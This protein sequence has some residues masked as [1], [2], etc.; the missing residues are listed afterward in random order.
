MKRTALILLL[1]T[2]PASADGG[3]AGFVVKVESSTVYLDAGEGSLA[4]P[5]RA[6]SVFAEGDELKHPVSGAS[7]GRIET[8]IASGE[9]VEVRGSY[10]LGRLLSTGT[11]QAVA[12]GQRFRFLDGEG[13]PR[14]LTAEAPAEKREDPWRKS[15]AYPLESVDLALADVDGDGRT[16]TVLASDN[17]VEAF[18]RDGGTSPVCSFKDDATSTRFLSLEALDLDQDGLEEA[19]VTVYNR[20]F[21]RLESYVLVCASGTFRRTAILPFMTRVFRSES[22]PALGAQSLIDDPNF[23]FQSI[24]KVEFSG[25]RYLRSK[26]K[27]RYPRVEWLYGFGVTPS[28][29][30]ALPYFITQTNRLRLQFGR[31]NWVSREAYC[32]TSNRLRWHDRFLQFY[33]R[34]AERKGPSGF[35]GLHALR[36]IPRFGSL[37]EAFGSFHHCELRFLRWTGASF[38]DER[39]IELPGY[40]S[41]LAQRAGELAVS[42]VEGDGRTVVWFFPN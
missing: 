39:G 9:I 37:S 11:A 22:G 4:R 20:L 27:L 7:L 34:M 24:H 30:G 33:P 8:D 10:S 5:G 2:A 16:E 13:A 17:R 6:F 21:E 23:P 19:F 42:V 40:A 28:D 12:A 18:S 14:P 29:A 38:Q 32:Q 25:G 26:D 3:K 15:P 36:N 1:S 35:E 31:K 41:G